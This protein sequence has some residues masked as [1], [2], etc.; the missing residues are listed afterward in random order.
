M[1]N[2]SFQWN[3]LD[4]NMITAKVAKLCMGVGCKAFRVLDHVLN[5]PV[6]PIRSCVVNVDRFELNV[7]RR[8]IL[9]IEA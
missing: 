4:Y 3:T 5:S 1:R 6:R 8:C 2:A 9:C 7:E